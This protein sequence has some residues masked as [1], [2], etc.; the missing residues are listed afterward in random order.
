VKRF[1]PSGSHEH[2]SATPSEQQEEEWDF[3]MKRNVPMLVGAIALAGVL[4]AATPALATPIVYN[5]TGGVATGKATLDFDTAGVL[6]ITLEN[7]TGNG[8]PW[9]GSI[10]QTITGLRFT[11]VG[12]GSVTGLTGA[13][14]DGVIRCNTVGTGDP[15]V[16]EPV[17]L[18][19]PYDW[20]WANGFGNN[21]GLFAGNG[22]KPYGIVND[23][24][25]S[26]DGLNSNAV[27]NPL[28][29]TSVFTLSV[30]G[31]ITG[32]SAA[33][34]YFGTA[35]DNATG[36]RCTACTPLL[37]ETPEPAT[38]ALLGSGLAGLV[39]RRRRRS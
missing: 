36:S 35:G 2:L 39:V 12:G 27:H 15:C 38:L 6:K 17:H 33:T 7:T 5:F 9:D 16:N 23:D 29:L 19:A 25:R 28:L 1:A 26:S 3:S 22:G 13:T 10:A 24:V 14:T 21:L 4:G 18:P 30:S 11:L 20:V 37:V 32:V 31:S 8:S 34:M